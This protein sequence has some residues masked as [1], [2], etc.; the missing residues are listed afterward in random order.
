[1]VF[2]DR[3]VCVWLHWYKQE[4]FRIKYA[5]YFDNTVVMLTL[6]TFT[7]AKRRTQCNIT[8]RT[9]LYAANVWCFSELKRLDVFTKL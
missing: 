3:S 2:S 6:F 9:N 8:H 4:Q 5:Q 7:F 1:M